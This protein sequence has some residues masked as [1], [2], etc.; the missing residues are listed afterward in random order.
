MENGVITTVAGTGTA[1]YS[2]DGSSAA[3]ARFDAP[4]ALA[5]DSQ[6]NLYIGDSNNN[7]IR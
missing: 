1:G 2:G 7:R 5:V 6:G 4:F 3:G